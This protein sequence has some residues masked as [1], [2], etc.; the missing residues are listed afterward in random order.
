MGYLK[1]HVYCLGTEL[2][3]KSS[4]IFNQIKH[5]FLYFVKGDSMDFSISE[6]QGQICEAIADMCKRKLNDNVYE[7][8]ENARFPMEKWKLCGNFGI[9]GLPIPEEYGGIGKSMLTTALGIKSLAYG[10]K[11]EGL[12]FSVCAHM[13]T[14]AIPIWRFGT[15]FQKEKYLSKLSSGELIGGNGITEADAGSDLSSVSTSAVKQSGGYLINGTK[16]FVSNSPIAD[17]LIIYAK[18]SNGIKMADISAFIIEKGDGGFKIGQVFNKMGL[19]TCPIAEVLLNDCITGEENLLGRERLGMLVFN[20]SM[21]WERIIM[22][23]YHIGSMEQQFE[24]VLSYANIR[25]QFNQKLKKFQS[26]SDKL[27]EM[28]ARIEQAKLM[29]YHACWKYDN[30]TLEVSDAS[31]LKLVTSEAKV[32]NSLDAIQIFGAYG[33]M[34]EYQVEKQLR[35]SLAAKIYS[36]TNEIQKKIIAEKLE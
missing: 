10:C 30:N 3:L 36:G 1:I 7:D 19:R 28:K 23:A 32:S 6:E 13:L 21:I 22:G 4:S 20:H 11:D 18:H 35:D 27:V 33:Y 8:D 24:E 14:C 26:I 15:D 34:K 16:I 5:L 17:I 29:L 12:V 25:K 2:Y 31:M 9:Q